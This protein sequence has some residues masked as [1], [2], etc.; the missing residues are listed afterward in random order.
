MYR[1]ICLAI[2]YLIGCLQTSYIAGKLNGRI[3]IREHGSG[4]AGTTNAIRVLGFKAGAIVFLCDVLKGSVAYI[5]CSLA[6]SGGGSFLSGDVGLFPFGGASALPGLYGGIGAILGHNFPFYMRFKGGK[7]V[8]AT[9]GLL[10]CFD[11]RVSL[12]A[13]AVIVIAAAASRYISLASLITAAL[14]PVLTLYCGYGRETIILMVILC[15]MTYV[16]HRANIK[17]LIQGSENKFSFR[18][19]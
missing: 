5:I 7:G 13:Y 8:A 16:Q 6:F 9:I 4:N 10:L 3:D 15:I 2:G 12:T 18:R 1:L 11:W 14:I 19:K 17:R